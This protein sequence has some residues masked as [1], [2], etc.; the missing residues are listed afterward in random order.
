MAYDNKKKWFTETIH[1]DI[2]TGEILGKN[3]LER[4][5]WIKKGN[6]KQVKDCGTYMLNKYIIKY[7]KSR[8][9]RIEF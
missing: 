5:D 2:E 1:I 7:E 9:L 8:Q 3:Q 4:E 6:E